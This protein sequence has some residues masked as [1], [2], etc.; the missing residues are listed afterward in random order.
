MSS[1]T[2]IQTSNLRTR[3]NCYL[4]YRNLSFTS[5][6]SM[7]SSIDILILLSPLFITVQPSNLLCVL[8]AG[9]FSVFDK[10]HVI[11]PVS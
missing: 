5:I 8:L 2:I 7:V 3:L 11:D 4:N 1:M 10:P 6:N 9:F